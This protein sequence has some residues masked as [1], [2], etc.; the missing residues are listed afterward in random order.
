MKFID[1]NNNE[2]EGIKI[3]PDPKWPG[4]MIVVLDTPRGHRQEWYPITDFLNANPKLKYLTE[5]APINPAE[6]VGVVS[7]A[8]KT[9][10]S[11]KT[12]KWQKDAYIGF[13]VWITRGKG[14]G[15][16]QTVTS[17]TANTI[18][19]KKEWQVLPNKT[20]QYCISRNIQDPVAYR[21]KAQTTKQ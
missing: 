15:Q 4:Y 8:T 11:D 7:R 18:L 16:I 5:G 3:Y 13:R 2:R 21:R 19:V 1:I 20:S 12:Q 14:N 10:L 6:C 17:N 9:S